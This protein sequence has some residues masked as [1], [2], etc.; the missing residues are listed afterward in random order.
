[1]LTAR[2]NNTVAVVSKVKCHGNLKMKLRKF[3][4]AQTQHNKLLVCGRR[5]KLTCK[6][7]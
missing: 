1:V 2:T 3:G 6:R 4:P 5:T 7:I